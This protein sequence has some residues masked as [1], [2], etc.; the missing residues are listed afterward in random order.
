[1]D[2]RIQQLVTPEDCAKFAKNAERLGRPD[3]ILEARRRAVELRAEKHGARSQAE[4]EALQAVYA[5]EEAQRRLTGRNF[6]ATRTWQ[7][8]ARRGIIEAVERA[9][10][11]SKETEGYRVL[12]EMKMQDLAFEA[13]V[14]RYPDLFS[15]ETVE[16]A[17]A[18]ITSWQVPE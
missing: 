17:R 3:L 11:R 4:R 7:M 18:R 10:N 12:A 5:Y 2:E 13:V 1:M 9:V 6:Q 15:S 8:I 16:R 14:L